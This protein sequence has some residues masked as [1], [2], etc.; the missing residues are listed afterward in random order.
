[1]G[2]KEKKYTK[3]ITKKAHPSVPTSVPTSL[4]YLFLYKNFPT[5]TFFSIYL[6]LSLFEQQPN[7]F[8]TIERYEFGQKR[9]NKND[10]WILSYD[11]FF[12]IVVVILF[13]FFGG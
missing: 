8:I 11:V 5:F 4:I 2:T 12:K 9:K 10:L 13:F 6:S 3:I 7:F 1:M